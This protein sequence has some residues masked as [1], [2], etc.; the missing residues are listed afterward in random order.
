MY[1]GLALETEIFVAFGGLE[2]DAVVLRTDLTTTAVASELAAV[3]NDR[4]I[5]R[6][7]L[8]NRLFY[9]LQ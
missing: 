7:F 2:V 5:R 4:R 3:S 1:S 6:N 8:P 9:L